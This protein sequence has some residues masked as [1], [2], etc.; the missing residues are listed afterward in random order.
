MKSSVSIKILF[1]IIGILFALNLIQF[2]TPNL[3][4]SYAAKNVEYK[5]IDTHVLRDPPPIDKFLNDLGKEGWELFL[6]ENGVM[7]F[8]R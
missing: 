8:K 3:Q 6:I 2:F 4:T 7:F 5:V 1:I